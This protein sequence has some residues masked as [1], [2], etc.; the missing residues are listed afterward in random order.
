MDRPGGY[1]VILAEKMMCATAAHVTSSEGCLSLSTPL[2]HCLAPCYLEARA[3]TEKFIGGLLSF[4][5][6]ESMTI[7]AGNMAAGRHGTKAT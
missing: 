2:L 7:I 5:G 4:G 6:L 3:L 1:E